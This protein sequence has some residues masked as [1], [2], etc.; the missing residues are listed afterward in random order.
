MKK[1]LYA[2]SIV[3]F[4]L[5]LI[6][7]PWFSVND[8]IL[9]ASGCPVERDLATYLTDQ[10]DVRAKT[11]PSNQRI[12]AKEIFSA[13]NISTGEG[14]V[15]NEG[16]WL[17]QDLG[18]QYQPLDLSGT[19]FWG[20]QHKNR[21]PGSLVTPQHVVAARH[22]HMTPGSGEYSFMD[23]N[24]VVYTRSIVKQTS[25][26]DDAHTQ[27]VRPTRASGT[28]DIVLQELNEPLPDSVHVYKVIDYKDLSE[29]LDQEKTFQR[30]NIRGLDSLKSLAI[31]AVNFNQFDQAGTRDV[32]SLGYGIGYAT[33]SFSA[34]ESYGVGFQAP[35][36]DRERADFTHGMIGGDSGDG[37]FF[38]IDNELTLLMTNL[39]SDDGPLHGGYIDSMN[40]VISSWGTS[41]YRIEKVDLGC[42]EKKNTPP[43]IETTQDFYIKRNSKVGD[44]FG[45]VDVRDTED[46]RGLDRF[47]LWGNG[48]ERDS[49]IL[50]KETG[51]L[52]V[53]GRI[54]DLKNRYTISQTK[55][56]ISSHTDKLLNL[57][58][59]VQD[60]N[61]VRASTRGNIRVHI[62]DD[63]SSP[64]ITPT[65]LQRP[66]RVGETNPAGSVIS[67]YIAEDPDGDDLS[68]SIQATA[69]SG[70]GSQ[71][72]FDINSR[73]GELVVT[74]D[75]ERQKFLNDTIN[76]S[77]S[78]L[79]KVADSGTPTRTNTYWADILITDEKEVNRSPVVFDQTFNT[80]S[81]GSKLVLFELGTV[82]ALDPD[83]G[84]RLQ[85]EIIDGFDGKLFNI[86]KDTG[87]ITLN[88]F[89]HSPDFETQ[90][91]YTVLVQVTD[92]YPEVS[93]RKSAQAK[94]TIPVLDLDEDLQ[95]KRD[96]QAATTIIF[97]PENKRASEKII[98][99]DPDDEVEVRYVLND[100]DSRGGGYF[101]VDQ[102]TGVVT[103][104]E[105]IDFEENLANHRLETRVGDVRDYFILQPV[106][107]GTDNQE[108]AI[109]ERLNVFV[110]DLDEKKSIANKDVYIFRS[111]NEAEVI[112]ESFTS[113]PVQ[114]SVVVPKVLLNESFTISGGKDAKLFE[115]IDGVLKF[116]TGERIQEG[117]YKV[118]IT[119]KDTLYGGVD[120]YS[121]VNAS[122]R[123]LN[124][125]LPLK[126]GEIH[127]DFLLDHKLSSNV[128]YDLLPGVS[129]SSEKLKLT[130]SDL[131]VYAAKKTLTIKIDKDSLIAENIIRTGC[132]DKRATNYD[133]DAEEDDGSCEYKD[134][135]KEEVI[136]DVRIDDTIFTV[137]P[138]QQQNTLTFTS[139]GGRS[140][141]H[142]II[143]E[144]YEGIDFGSGTGKAHSFTLEGDKTK[145]ITMSALSGNQDMQEIKTVRGSVRTTKQVPLFQSVRSGS[146]ESRSGSFESGVTKAQT[147]T[148]NFDLLVIIEANNSVV[149]STSS[150]G[151][152][153]GSSHS[154]RDEG[155]TDKRATNYDRG[156]KKDDGS[157]EY[158]SIET[159]LA[160]QD[161]AQSKLATELKERVRG[162]LN[163]LLVRLK[164]QLRE[165][166][167][168]KGIDPSLYLD[169]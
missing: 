95:V 109:D 133:K 10:V 8:Y 27:R 82:E 145:V 34:T 64:V 48:Q 47:I 118:E 32:S 168:K 113:D 157:C 155:C 33:N 88:G 154:N 23:H 9:L 79:L 160:A 117:E 30:Y 13:R 153:G 165:L 140:A 116:K 77:C 138:S 97:V 135:K 90:D 147:K 144:G 127:P 142:T 84:Q 129:V 123:S 59:V 68:W 141:E 87:V 42:F 61:S 108:R 57:E 94:I 124:N 86:N 136:A 128:Y 16:N 119:L 35:K 54:E 76:P 28:P 158:D 99:D 50:D 25:I 166:L 5:S 121:F 51:F 126:N 71:S 73:T 4:T 101:T 92:N 111:Q 58:V 120:T 19:S 12:A 115:M 26:Y 31:P 62:V 149:R 114:G 151:G 78:L 96:T 36:E 52:S 55:T 39:S 106:I 38:I 143:V 148:S 110:F 63:N 18:A 130:Q 89:A 107:T 91:E 159:N 15:Y 17:R 75:S 81:E 122:D 56:E 67:Q 104:K 163:Q 137:N 74:T 162:L 80:I 98:I 83:P 49:V 105:G 152:G 72:P 14:Y 69:C 112:L 53:A 43:V 24:G 66:L 131:D 11:V 37:A 60:D 150:G 3:F 21:F 1:P 93:L 103:M 164:S 70:S 6:L 44:I 2:A 41:P 85:F 46:G 102:K 167:I 146:Y 125:L 29:Y 20:S 139:V 65:I 45:R 7:P 134:T 132:V 100:E 40:K 161:V 156:A 169:N 22:A